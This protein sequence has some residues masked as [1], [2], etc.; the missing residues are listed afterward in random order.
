MD[1]K[2]DECG[3]YGDIHKLRSKVTQEIIYACYECD[4]MWY[5][6]GYFLDD[7]VDRYLNI[8]GIIKKFD[9]V[10]E[11]IWNKLDDSI[12]LYFFV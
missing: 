2:C 12:D 8:D 10:F 5:E 1:F 6:D 11:E 7:L 9:D 3:P 4:S